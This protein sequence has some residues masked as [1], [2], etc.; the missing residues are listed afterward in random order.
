VVAVA[1]AP[2][3][4][5][6]AAVVHSRTYGYGSPTEGRRDAAT[7]VEGAMWHKYA[8]DGARDGVLFSLAHRLV[9]GVVGSLGSLVQHFVPIVDWPRPRSSPP[10]R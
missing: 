7:L 3:G 8:V 2:P 6:N 9:R 10:P 5:P 4:F 1:H